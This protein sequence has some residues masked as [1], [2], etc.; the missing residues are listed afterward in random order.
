LEDIGLST[1]SLV[2]FKQGFYIDGIGGSLARQAWHKE[3]SSGDSV[4]YDHEL[5]TVGRAGWLV[6]RFT[7]SSDASGRQQYPLVVAVHGTDMG[8]LQ[9]LSAMLDELDAQ[10][11]A[12]AQLKD[13][14]ALRQAQVQGQAEWTA[15]MTKWCAEP[16]LSR[17][18]KE[19]WLK[20]GDLG[21][22][23][24]GLQRVCHALLPQGAGAGKARVPLV[25][26]DLGLSRV[27]WLSF[28]HELLSHQA[29]VLTLVTKHGETFGDLVLGP[30]GARGLTALFA[31]LNA[32]PL[33]SSIPF[34]LADGLAEAVDT[35]A[36]A[37]KEQP[38]LFTQADPGEDSPDGLL[39]RI[40]SGFRS[41]LKS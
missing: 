36:E 41:W 18:M 37:W 22:D 25:G 5:I 17:Q 14:A 31:G 1:A 11:D 4:P 39:Q 20:A 2:A 9:H 24:L 34:N 21:P 26:V 13:G 7:H 8:A 38:A 15:S 6:A 27:F 23:L 12:A 35:A 28:V 40:C 10:S 16:V 3:L 32:Q 19:A 30:P 29:P 33:T